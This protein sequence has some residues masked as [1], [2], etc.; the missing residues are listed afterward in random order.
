M[1]PVFTVL[2]NNSI[3]KNIFLLQDNHSQ[4][5]PS[6]SSFSAL[7]LRLSELEGSNPESEET[8]VVGRH[9]ECNIT[10]EHPSI[11]RFHLRIHSKP[12]LQKLS[13]IDLSSVHGTWVSGEK[14]K[15]GVRV[16]MR[17]GDTV[18]LG[19][20]TRV[21]RLDWIP[22]S[23]AY[24]LENPF[25]PLLDGSG[26]V[27]ET[28]EEAYKDEN[29][30]SIGNK[31]FESPDEYL[32]GLDM[33]FTN[34]NLTSCLKKVS[35]SAPPMQ[36]YTKCSYDKEQEVENKDT[37]WRG[38]EVSEIS[39][40][41][42]E[43]Q[44]KDS[45]LQNAN[46]QLFNKEILGVFSETEN[47]GSPSRNSGE[48]L[49]LLKHSKSSFCDDKIE[50]LGSD[51]KEHKNGEVSIFSPQLL[52]GDHN[53]FDK[54]N[55]IS[56]KTEQKPILTG[57]L[58][59]SPSGESG[60]CPVGKVSESQ[61]LLRE[62]HE[63]K[64][65]LSEIVIE[66]LDKENN[67]SQ[68]FINGTSEIESPESPLVTSEQR[69]NLG[70]IWSRRGK[71][72]SVQI[73]TTESRRKSTRVDIDAE[74]EHLNR[75]IKCEYISKCLLYSACGEEEENFTPDKENYPTNT[76]R[77]MKKASNVEEIKHSMSYRSSPLKNSSVVGPNIHGKEN[78]I[79]SSD[80]ENQTQKVVAH[81]AKFVGPARYQERLQSELTIPKT[82]ANRLPFQALTKIKVNSMSSK[83]KA[84]VLSATR[85][86][87]NSVNYPGS[88]EKTTYPWNNTAEGRPKRWILVVDV[89]CFVN[90]DS[91]KALQLLR[92][93]RGTQLIIPRI[94]VRELD[95]MKRRSSLFSRT[96]EAS[97]A[98]QW[99]EECMMNTKWWIHV[100]STIEEGRPFA[101]TP[102]SS[103]VSQFSEETGGAYPLGS[104][105]FSVCGSL[106]DIVSPTAED[107]ILECALLFKKVKNDG[108]LVLLSDD[109]T[110]KIKAMAE[111]LMCETA[112]D[113]RESLVNPFSER[114]LWADS[115]PRGP[116]WSFKDDVV[117]KEKYHRCPIKKSSTLGEG[118]KGLKLILL[119]SSHYKQFGS[120]C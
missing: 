31:K 108:Q 25:V 74:I 58:S 102:P 42:P 94:V 86:S 100:Q 70:S 82:R 37:S 34:K 93:L 46:N 88:E 6:I 27:N 54:E 56:R 50:N 99:I 49:S 67:T 21:Y 47:P 85:R 9:P 64:R 87:S 89:S 106:L 12:S 90:K 11:S 98:L 19:G 44:M 15:P 30:S 112:E 96:A 55:H 113:F 59:S 75:D 41:W 39:G 81:E 43:Q 62:N 57:N 60:G 1:I 119:H 105:P 97:S 24:D 2:K 40:I 79:V 17:E 10:L 83:S 61:K 68:A 8:L 66:Q 120:V 114:F 76:L 110:L 20:S 72:A 103:P 7:A 3:L 16:E 45:V 111:G 35:P 117:L 95:C 118:A 91:N 48:D 63:E 115:S 5:P 14:I 73:Q 22:L 38:N 104:V 65:M 80:K 71:T 23:R 32:D 84:S 13:V 18:K 77:S 29:C 36:A 51:G 116:T 92:G 109:V 26:S 4:N 53:D 28:E 52:T 69:P 101:P 107:H 33:L 78:M